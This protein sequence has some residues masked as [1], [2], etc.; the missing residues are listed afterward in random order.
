MIFGK[1]NEQRA[2]EV[3]CKQDW[4][5]WYAWRIVRLDTGRLVWLETVQRKGTIQDSWEGQEWSW[6]YAERIN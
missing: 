3:R 6:D 1:S 2:R 5:R 4:H